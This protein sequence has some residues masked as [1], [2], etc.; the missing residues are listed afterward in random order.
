M[1]AL[2]N[3]AFETLKLNFVYVPLIITDIQKG[4]DA[5][6]SLGIHAVGVTIP[7]K[8]SCVPFLDKLDKNAT[9]IGAVNVII[10]NNGVLTG[11]NTDGIGAVMALKEITQIKG[12]KVLLLGAGGAARAIAFSVKD[13]CGD[14][15]IMNRTKSEAH[16]LATAVGCTWNSFDKLQS[17]VDNADI[18][19]NSTSVGMKPNS[20]ETLIPKELLHNKPTVMD[21]VSNPKLTRLLNDATNMNCKTVF[22]DRM[23]LWQAVE[24]F[25]LYTG[26]EAPIDV[27]ER[28][29]QEAE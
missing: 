23:L 26:I 20:K 11:G 4:I 15:T 13:E 10:N 27:F 14:L 9:R 21:V 29:L 5:I 16:K 22:A 7:F 12:K 2:Y 28:A 1:Y 25:T 6:R 8:I 17:I 19:I 3:A 18:V 24:K